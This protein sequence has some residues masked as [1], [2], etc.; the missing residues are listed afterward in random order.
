MS[1]LVVIFHYECFVQLFIFKIMDEKAFNIDAPSRRGAREGSATPS[2][3][4]KSPDS[5]ATKIL[6]RW[7]RTDSRAPAAPRWS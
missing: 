4:R 1:Y 6:S 7:S 5:G 2:R 3:G